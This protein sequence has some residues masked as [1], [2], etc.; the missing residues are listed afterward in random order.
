MTNIE[1]AA[2]AIFVGLMFIVI[3]F[4]AF[5]DFGDVSP[6]D[7]RFMQVEHRLDVLERAQ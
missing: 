7:H 6:I 5:Y 3:T 4:L 2:I 1:V